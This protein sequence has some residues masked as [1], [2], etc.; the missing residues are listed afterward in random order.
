MEL[1]LFAAPN[2]TENAVRFIDAV[3]QVPNIF[4]G[5][6]SQ[7]P[8][9]RLPLEVQQKVRAFRQVGNIFDRE[10][11]A[12]AVRAVARP[13][14][15]VHRLLVTVEQL[16]E[17]VAEVREML[18]IA[19][20]PAEK[21]R[22]FRD[23]ARMK[24]K[25]R[26]AGLPCAH[27][28]LAAGRE[29]A[30]QFAESVGFPIV[31]K[32]PDGAASQS[33]YKV[34]SFDELNNVLNQ[35]EPT[36]HRRVLLEEFITGSEHSFDTFSLKGTPLFHSLTHYDPTPLDVMRESWIQWQVLLPREVDDPKY[37]DIRQAA[38]RALEVLGMETGLSHLEWFR[39]KD[40]TIA[41]SE[42]AARPPGAQI[43]TLISRAND[44]D[45]VAAWA[46]L[47][48][49]DSFNVPERKYAVGAAYLRGSGQGKVVAVHGLEEV[50][51][52]VG[53]LI[54]DLKL[55]RFGQEKSLSYEG[56]GYIILRHPETAVVKQALMRVVSLVRVELA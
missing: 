16:Q 23:K 17:V 10:E 2:F 36:I 30:R 29:D 46:K 22:N 38:F 11:L 28:R 27:H 43:T 33:T 31:V 8:R 13:Y 1:V 12:E 9:D 21:I 32:P 40:G 49:R 25:L 4:F 19:G 34:Q 48:G 26:A 42:V 53:R 14:G 3:A 7:E 24:D 20:M 55:P 41:I 6:I 47:M 15:T 50:E 52:E 39:R 5:L 44:F 35:L 37:D 18:D 51:K 45:A 56:E 54:C